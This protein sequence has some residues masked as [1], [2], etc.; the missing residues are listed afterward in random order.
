MHRRDVALVAV[1]LFGLGLVLTAPPEPMYSMSVDATPN[2]DPTDV[3]EF[4]DLDTDA[5]QEFLSLLEGERWRS[6]H[7]PA[8]E[9]AFVRY[10]DSRYR[11]SVSVSESSVFSLLQPVVGGG[12]LLVGAVGLVIR[13]VS[14]RYRG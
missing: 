4:V 14:P 11:V 8:L 9:N 7:P 13:R 3:I 1:A 5:Q 12:V 10:K 6:S 2:A